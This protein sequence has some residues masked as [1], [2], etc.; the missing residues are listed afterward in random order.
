MKLNALTLVLL[1]GLLAAPPS[2]L[3]KRKN[4]KPTA[5]PSPTPTTSVFD[6][7]VVSAAQSDMDRILQ[8]EDLRK[9]RDPHLLSAIQGSSESKALM[10]LQAVGRIG[11]PNAMDAITRILRRRDVGGNRMKIAAAT[12]LGLIQNKNAIKELTQNVVMQRDPAVIAAVLISIGR[13]GNEQS[14]NTI[15]NA[16][17]DNTKPIVLDAGAHALGSLWSG[18]SEKWA[19]PLALSDEKPGLIE[20]LTALAKEPGNVGLSAAFALSRFKGDP[21]LLP[22]DKIIETAQSTSS[23]DVRALLCRV[24]GKTKTAAASHF[25]SQQVLHDT[26][27]GTRIEAIKALAGHGITEESQTAYKKAMGDSASSLA[28][29]ERGRAQIALPHSGEHRSPACERSFKSAQLAVI[30]RGRGMFGDSGTE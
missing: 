6:G 20:K 13:A 28:L 16:L 18:G 12:A 9:E 15:Y 7:P 10:A 5:A 17:L 19:V 27:L 24:L 29:G 22:T 3:A 1:L 4:R 25:L 30:T 21:T 11:D 14:V 23:S 2:A 8:A 26:H